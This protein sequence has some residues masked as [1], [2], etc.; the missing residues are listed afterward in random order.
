MVSKI[1]PKLGNQKSVYVGIGLYALGMFL[2]AFASQSWMMFVF[3]IPYCLGGISGPAIQAVIAN[4]VPANEQGA[5]QGTMASVMSASMIVGP[6]VMSMIFYYFTHSDAP[7]KF[8]GTPFVL[9]GILM[10]I[11]AIIA[12]RSF[13]RN[14]SKS[15]IQ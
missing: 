7:F 2:F 11:S 8:A 6:P 9:G 14:N 1:N 15:A 4:E 13:K 3:L 5:I 10:V 12:Y